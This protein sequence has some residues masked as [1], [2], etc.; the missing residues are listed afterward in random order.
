M[1]FIP[2]ISRFAQTN[3]TNFTPLAD[4]L[5]DWAESRECW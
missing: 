3:T 4:A 5:S 1:K 2:Y